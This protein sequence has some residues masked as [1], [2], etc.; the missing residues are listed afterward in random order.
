M[1]TG[2]ERPG[3]DLDK[4]QSKDLGTVWRKEG[5]G[6]GVGDLVLNI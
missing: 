2:S 5:E 1:N 6:K 4:E 3:N